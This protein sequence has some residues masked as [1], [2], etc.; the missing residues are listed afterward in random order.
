[1]DTQ[2]ALQLAAISSWLLG[3]FIKL[4]AEGFVKKVGEKLGDEFVVVAKSLLEKVSTRASADQPEDQLAQVVKDLSKSDQAFSTQGQELIEGVWPALSR[5]LNQ[6]GVTPD[7]ILR[8]Y[9][10]FADDATKHGRTQAEQ[11]NYLITYAHKPGK[12][13]LVLK[14]IQDACP[15]LLGE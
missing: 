5:L 6:P 9:Q 4:G 12:L 13:M 14:A 2:T 7:D 11:V 15:D 10:R 8:I 1:M 3:P